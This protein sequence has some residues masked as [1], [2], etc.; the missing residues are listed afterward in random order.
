MEHKIIDNQHL[1]NESSR[2]YDRVVCMLQAIMR[3]IGPELRANART[4]FTCKR[5]DVLHVASHEGRQMQN[6]APKRRTTLLY[7]LLS[8]VLTGT[9][10]ATLHGVDSNDT[11]PSTRP[12]KSTQVPS[13]MDLQ[14][15]PIRIAQSAWLHLSALLAARSKAG[16][17][18]QPWSSPGPRKHH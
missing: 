13:V 2:A 6:H 16:N 15:I 4:R 1:Q 11:S 14:V 18:T 5:T 10:E 3:R 17:Q 7:F 9:K 12:L 8:L